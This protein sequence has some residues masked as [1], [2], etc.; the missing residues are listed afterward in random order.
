MSNIN[1]PMYNEFVENDD[2][3]NEVVNEEILDR[4]PSQVKSTLWRDGTTHDGVDALQTCPTESA[5]EQILS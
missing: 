4:V 3:C 2:V 5:F 1:N